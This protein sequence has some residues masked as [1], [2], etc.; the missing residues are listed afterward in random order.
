MRLFY[1]I[2][3]SN[4]CKTYIDSYNKALKEKSL[5]G[6]FTNRDNFH[7][8]LEFIGEVEK[9][10]LNKFKNILYKLPNKKVSLRTKSIGK[11]KKRGG[12]IVWISLERS[13]P[14]ENLV[15]KLIKRLEVVGHMPQFKEYTPHITLGRG[16]V[17]DNLPLPKLDPVILE[18]DSIAL[19]ESKRVDNRLIYKPVY[20]VKFIE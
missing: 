3:L 10:D 1:A 11:F 2:T 19:M 9:S 13:K 20:E 16:V 5:K 15:N 17:F 8:T 6:K 12:D 14:L 7:L 18:V 4:S